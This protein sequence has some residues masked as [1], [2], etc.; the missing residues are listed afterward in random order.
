MGFPCGLLGCSQE[1]EKGLCGGCGTIRYCGKEHQKEDWRRHKNE[2]KAGAEEKKGDVKPK[3]HLEYKEAYPADKG[4]FSTLREWFGNFEMMSWNMHRG[5]PG[6][7]GCILNSFGTME[8]ILSK[9]WGFSVKTEPGILDFLRTESNAVGKVWRGHPK[10]ARSIPFGTVVLSDG[11]TIQMIKMQN[12]R[13]TPSLKIELERGETYVSLGFVDLQELME[14]NV[15]GLP[16]NGPIAWHGYDMNPIAVGRSKLIL[17]MLE[18]DVPLDQIV[19]IWFSTCISSETAKTLSAF[20]GKL[21]MFERDEDVRTLLDWWSRASGSVKVETSRFAWNKGRRD[22]A[23]TSI[24]LLLSRKDRVEYAHYILTGQIF[25]AGGA[26]KLTGNPTFL[27]HEQHYIPPSNESIFDTLNISQEL[28]CEGSLLAS[29]EKRFLGNLATLRKRL[30][31]NQIKITLSVA[32]ISADNKALL[33]EI[34]RL[35]PAAIEWSNIPDY[36]TIPQFFSI[37]SQ[38]SVEGTRHSFH[39]MN[40]LEKVFG[41]NLADYVPFRENYTYRNFNLKGFFKDSGDALPKL[42]EELKT[43]L[44]S[45]CQVPSAIT[46]DLGVVASLMNMMDISTAAFSF[47][48]CDTYMNFMFENVELAKKEWEK[49]EMSVFDHIN[50]TVYASFEF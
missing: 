12:M 32:T 33:T 15:G 49:A 5:V 46:Q 36:F 50:S 29:I 14:A 9:R 6:L 44:M 26:N 37:A 11:R 34:K 35:K 19:Q 20:C 21:R 27:P 41:A 4:G 28:L 40:W 47:R 45:Q 17:A 13:N 18:E 31:E 3:F 16:E 30:K 2:C 25:L 10:L 1:V 39:L 22:G 8:Q 48:F 38:C 42:I 7:Q 43:E 24:P 23:F